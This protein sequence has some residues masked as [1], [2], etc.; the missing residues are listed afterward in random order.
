MKN[1][2]VPLLVAMLSLVASS[3]FSTLLYYDGFPTTGANAY[4]L[5]QLTSGINP[6]HSSIVGFKDNA[7]NTWQAGSTAIRISANNLVPPVDVKLTTQDSCFS[8]GEGSGSPRAGYRNIVT[9][10]LSGTTYYSFLIKYKG[11]FPAGFNNDFVS[12][13]TLGYSSSNNATIDRLGT[14]GFVVAF[15]RQ[16]ASTVNLVLQTDTSTQTLVANA[17]AG[18]T[19]MVAA[20]Y[21][22]NPGAAHQ[23]Y[24]SVITQPQEPETWDVSVTTPIRSQTINKMCIG[25]YGGNSTVNCFLVDEIR[26]GTTFQDVAGVAGVEPAVF[27]GTTSISGISADASFG[28]ATFTGTLS[29]P[30]DPVADLYLYWGQT[31]GGTTDPLTWA[32]TGFVAQASAATF[33]TN[34][35]ILPKDSMVF[36][37]LA[38]VTPSQKVWGVPDPAAL[39]TAPLTVA[40]SGSI[41]ENSLSPASFV[42]SRPDTAAALTAPLQV[43]FVLGGTAQ[44]GVHYTASSTTSVT[45]PAA[46][47]SV[48]VLIQPIPDFTSETEHTV[49]LVVQPGMYVAS[50]VATG[51]LTIVNVAVPNAPTNAFTGALSSLASVPENW[52]LGRVPAAGDDIL[53]SAAFAR[54]P[55]IWD[56]QAPT[57]IAS[58]T[59]PLAN[60]NTVFFGT[61]LDSPLHILGDVDLNG[62]VWTH[63]GPSNAPIYAVAV[64]IDGDLSVGANAAINVGRDISVIDPAGNTR[65]FY[66]E[67]LGY[68]SGTGSSYGGEGFTNAVTYGSVINPLSYGSGARGGGGEA[69]LLKYSGGGLVR[70]RVGGTATVLGK[71]AADGYGY[72]N[73]GGGGTGGTLNLEAGKLMGTGAITANGG[74]DTYF[75]SGAGGRIRIKLTNPDALVSDFTGTLTAYGAPGGAPGGSAQYDT[76]GAAAGTIAFGASQMDAGVATVLVRNHDNWRAMTNEVYQFI[77]STH[78]PPKLDTDASL[79]ATSWVLG[80][81]AK[82]RLTKSITVAS[83]TM[84]APVSVNAVSP[85]LYLEG[86]SLSMLALDVDG[87]AYSAGTYSASDFPAGWVTGLGSVIVQNESTLI[88]VR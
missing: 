21:V 3:A 40:S 86:H 59:Q 1:N 66:R 43:N 46:T 69:S 6:Q 22:N 15:V 67:G 10:A 78:L 20:K 35:V 12:F 33:S 36:Y 74:N 41:A 77:P 63:L 48:S 31:D 49:T 72:G 5:G 50:A 55:L 4:T 53:F 25:G 57:T 62:G 37:R 68:L 56:A 87:E 32:N 47:N 73:N 34:V 85:V 80:D 58:W 24:A 65:G 14:N 51:M 13:D 76:A 27:T 61:T 8:V 38:A 42:I 45:I 64:D 2:P 16:D 71:I 28:S 54:V 30:G 83:F 44:Y 52:S 88:T 29:F 82:V 17:S 7:A 18:T 39:L 70:I 75:G 9:P 23:V 26:I 11:A 84:L 60:T 19:Y 81:N 79:K